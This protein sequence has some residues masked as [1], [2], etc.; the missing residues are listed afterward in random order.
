MAV[1]V[2]GQL[3]TSLNEEEETETFPLCSHI[4]DSLSGS[5]IRVEEVGQ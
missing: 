1:A 2:K 5:T 4:A 3:S